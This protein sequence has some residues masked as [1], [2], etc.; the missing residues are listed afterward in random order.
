MLKQLYHTL[1]GRGSRNTGMHAG[2]EN[3]D[4]HGTTILRGG[5]SDRQI[6]E[7]ACEESSLHIYITIVC[8]IDV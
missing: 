3:C 4:Y 1:E 2:R 6:G 7:I 5:I 8:F